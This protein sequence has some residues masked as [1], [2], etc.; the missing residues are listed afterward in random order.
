[1]ELQRL[2]KLERQPWPKWRQ[3]QYSWRWLEL[4][5]FAQMVAPALVALADL[6]W[7]LVAVFVALGSVDSCCFN[8]AR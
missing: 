5:E 4:A 3:R 7:R 8:A 6:A 2:E 1:M